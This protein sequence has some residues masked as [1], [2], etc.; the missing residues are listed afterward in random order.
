[1]KLILFS[2]FQELNCICHYEN[3]NLPIRSLVKKVCFERKNPSQQISF[4]YISLEMDI[5]LIFKIFFYALNPIW[6]LN[7]F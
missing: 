6:Y 4:P 3:F 2:A 7:T 1:M 5:C